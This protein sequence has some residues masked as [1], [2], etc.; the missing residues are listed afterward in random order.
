MVKVHQWTSTGL[1]FRIYTG[2]EFHFD[3]KSSTFTNFDKFTN[4]VKRRRK[5]DFTMSKFNGNMFQTM[6]RITHYLIKRWNGK[7]W[8][9][10]NGDRNKYDKLGG[11]DKGVE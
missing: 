1:E 4:D 3:K 2:L 6:E 5:V 9:R 11:S 10:K 8:V 7:Y